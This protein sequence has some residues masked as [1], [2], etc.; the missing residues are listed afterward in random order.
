MPVWGRKKTKM[1]TMKIQA[2]VNVSKPQFVGMSESIR[3]EGGQVKIEASTIQELD[4][5]LGDLSVEYGEDGGSS[6]LITVLIGGRYITAEQ[7]Y[8]K[9]TELE[10]A[11]GHN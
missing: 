2:W 7:F 3:N 9:A 6:K 4:S 5:K 11:E 1:K 10:K 8:M